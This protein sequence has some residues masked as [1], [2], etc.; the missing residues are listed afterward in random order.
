MEPV[1][2]NLILCNLISTFDWVA[3][4]VR[5]TVTMGAVTIYPW[6]F[7][8]V[9][10][11][12]AGSIGASP[13]YFIARFARALPDKLHGSTTNHWA[14]L[15]RW[16]RRITEHPLALKLMAR[17]G[18]LKT[19]VVNHRF[20]RNLV[21]RLR[22]HI[23]LWHVAIFS[24]PYFDMVGIGVAGLEKYPLRR[25][26]PALVIGRCI[27]N[28]PVVLS[29]L[30]LVRFAWFQSVVDAMHH[31]AVGIGLLSILVVGITIGLYQINKAQVID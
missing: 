28:I 15:D 20:A 1:L 11:S 26:L 27:H 8:L 10:A 17:W 9:V 31:P 22:R 14:F 13:I 5:V 6:W 25:F 23:F 7:V 4:P 2:W 19:S 16:Q 21:A 18:R 30:L 29:G 24:I 3:A 12:I